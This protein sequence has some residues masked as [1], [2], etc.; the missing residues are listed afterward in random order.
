MTEKNPWANKMWTEI[1]E[2]MGKLFPW[3]WQAL[4]DHSCE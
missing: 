4:V 1:F 2:E 3:S